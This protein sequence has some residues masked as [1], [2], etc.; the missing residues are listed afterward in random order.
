M[1]AEPTGER[2][3]PAL[4]ARIAARLCA[5]NPVVRAFFAS[6]APRLALACQAMAERFLRGGRLY[7]FGRGPYATDAAHV[8]VEFVHPV[9][10]GKRALP[11]LD[12]SAAPQAWL[13]VLAG[14]DDIAVAFGPPQGDAALLAIL[15][16]ARAAGTL[17]LA[18]PGTERDADYAFAAPSDDPHLH[19]ELFEVLGHT[20]YESVHV[21]FEYR[22]HGHDVGASAF[23]YPYLGSA[24]QDTAAILAD[25]AAS[26]VAKARDGELLREQVA[27]RQ[28]EAI[29][30]AAQAIAERLARGGRV[31]A[32][33]NGGSS[34]D[35]T[36]FAIDCVDPPPGM[37]PV[38]ALS[39]ASEPAILS[40][41]GNDVGV[42]L[43]FSRQIIAQA[44]PVDVAFAFST[45]G[46]SKNVV[47]ALGEARK[48]G[49]LTVALLGYD[50][51]E[52]ARRGLADHTIVVDCD[53]IPR[54]QETQ[55]AIY[56]ELRRGFELCADDA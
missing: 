42:E 6:E 30:R 26:I 5:R 11:A 19:Q 4:A 38:P 53:Y 12:L 3:V 45:S 40:A 43:V 9:I 33:G 50:G 20:L 31:L 46:G 29:A 34:T 10:V 27:E 52:I 21:F 51:G 23:L 35:A 13:E 44:R 18:L 17:T 56:H 28:A 2:A 55:G 41:I 14:S 16:R 32:F 37:R 22:E 15:A 36:D 39:L 24:K 8:S 54:I 48:R 49:L 47:A 25:V 1:K 7:A